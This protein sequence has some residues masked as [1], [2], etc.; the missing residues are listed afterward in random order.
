MKQYHRTRTRER[1]NGWVIDYQPRYKR[2]AVQQFE[3][4]FEIIAVFPT[5][6]R[7]RVWAL[8]HLKRAQ[9]AKLV[10]TRQKQQLQQYNQD[11]INNLAEKTLTT[12]LLA[13]Y[14]PTCRQKTRKQLEKTI[15]N[16]TKTASD[17]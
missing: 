17:V 11:T 5:R 12:E 6:Q 8:S 13:A 3:P 1:L 16:Q 7:A 15:K 2:F 14:K 9:I 10:G 4:F